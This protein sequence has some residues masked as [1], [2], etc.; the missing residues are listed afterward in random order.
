MARQ[1]TLL[2]ITGADAGEPHT[3]ERV[4]WKCVP[5]EGYLVHGLVEV[6]RPSRWSLRS[7]GAWRLAVARVRPKT[8]AQAV[9][10]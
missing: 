2:L 9:T 10:P 8:M 4:A 3:G 6:A 5:H 1:H 7:A